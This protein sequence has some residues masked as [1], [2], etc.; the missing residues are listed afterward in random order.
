MATGHQNNQ[1]GTDPIIVTGKS[2]R[3]ESVMDAFVVTV[4]FAQDA[5]YALGRVAKRLPEGFKLTGR[6]SVRD[7]RK[8]MIDVEV[9][10]LGGDRNNCWVILTSYGMSPSADLGSHW[11]ELIG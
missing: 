2:R 11:E 3:K 9:E 5:E 6:T 8:M 1:I 10:N 4:S 7:E